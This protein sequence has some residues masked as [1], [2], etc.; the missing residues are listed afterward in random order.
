MATAVEV[1][2]RFSWYELM[3]TDPKAAQSFYTRLL[4]WGLQDFNAGAN[5]PYVMWT[6]SNQPFGGVMTLPEEARK[7]GAPPHWLAYVDVAKVDATVE[8]A[9]G[10]G[11]KVYVPPMD[12]PGGGRFAVL[13]DPQGAVFGVV[14]SAQPTPEPA[15]P[16]VPQVGEF[17]WHELMTTDYGAAFS[18]YNALF[19]WEKGEAAD[20]GPMGIYQMFG[21]RGRPLGGMMNKPPQMPAPPHWMLYIRVPDVDK[22]AEQVK[23]MGGRILN[24]PMDVPGGDRVVQCADPQG[25]AFA[26]HQRK[27]P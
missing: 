11:A 9:K 8:Q 7:M 16:A 3:T 2:R 12:I 26:L 10:L 15:E 19:G 21:R 27:N 1:Q 24:G 18:F 5:E 6:R 22:A 23:A 4:G 20:M 17:S 25:A 14:S 13:A